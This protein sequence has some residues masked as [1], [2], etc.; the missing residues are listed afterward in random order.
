MFERNIRGKLDVTRKIFPP[1]QS[2][3]GEPI[4]PGK[5]AGMVRAVEKRG[6]INFK[7]LL[8]YK[9]FQPPQSS[10]PLTIN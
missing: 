9:A 3:A 2:R 10:S 5:P 1:V 6:Q 8:Y 4:S 7:L